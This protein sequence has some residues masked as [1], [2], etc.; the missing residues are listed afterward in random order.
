M[1][2]LFFRSI[3]IAAFLLLYCRLGA[4]V[5]IADGLPGCLPVV[6]KVGVPCGGGT[7]MFDVNG[8]GQFVVNNIDGA[9][10]CSMAGGD[11]E[12]YFEFPSLN[13]AG[14]NNVNI[15]MDYS[16]ANTSYEDNSTG[17]NPIFGCQ[18]MTP[19]DNSHD[20]IIFTYSLDGA[21]FVQGLYLHGTT[22]ADFTGTW[23]EGPLNGNSLV[24]RV[25]AS[26]KAQAEIFYF[27]NLL[28][29]G[30]SS[31]TAGPD[32]EGCAGVP[33][34][35]M[36]EGS[37][38]WTG[39]SGSFANV[40]DP[41]TTYTPAASEQGNDIT[42]TF[43]ATPAYTGCPAT[44]DEMV[45]SVTDGP[46]IVI[47]PDPE[48]C[49]NAVITASGGVSYSWSGGQTPLQAENTFTQSGTYVVTVT[50][51]SGC[52]GTASQQVTVNSS[53][54]VNITGNTTGC[55]SVTLTASGGGP[56]GSYSWSGGS[57]PSSATNT[58]TASGTYVVTVTDGN[59]CTA[60]GSA[61]VTVNQGPVGM[62][63][64]SAVLCPGQCATFS[65]TF[66]SGSGTY[67]VN[68]TANPPG[69]NLPPVPGIT[70][71]ST[72]TVCYQG[73]G[74][75]PT[76]NQ[77]TLTLTIPTTFSGTGGLTLTGIS[78]GSGCPGM[79]SGSFN[80]TL[81]NAPTIQN[82]GPLT[83][84]ANMNGE[85]IFNL[86][87]L[88]GTLTGGNSNLTVNWF[89]DAAGTDPITNPSNYESGTTTVYVSVSNGACSSPIIEVDLIVE[90][91]DVPFISMVCAE[92]GTDICTVCAEN[93]LTDLEFN[94]GDN[95]S[96]SV[97]VREI[98]TGIDYIGTVSN[99]QPLAVLSG[100]SSVF[101]LIN[102]QPLTGCPSFGSYGQ[103][104]TV[105][106]VQKPQ[107]DPVTIP[108]SCDAVVLPPITGN[109]LSGNE[110]YYS[111]PGGTGDVYMPG[112]QI[113]GSITLFLFDTTAPGCEDE[114]QVIITILPVVIFN[115]I[116]DLT[117]CGRVFLPAID[118]VNVSPNA[119]YN[120]APDGSGV[121]YRPNEAIEFNT[122]LY[123]L[124]PEADSECIVNQ[125]DVNITVFPFPSV[126]S[127]EVVCLPGSGT[128]VV[129][130]SSPLDP[131]M[132][133]SLDGIN[134]QNSPVFSNVV[135]G[136]YILRFKDAENECEQIL[137]FSVNCDCAKPAYL[138]I[139]VYDENICAS[140]TFRLSDVQFGGS[141]TNVTLKHNGTG[142]LSPLFSDEWPIEVMYIPGPGDTGNEIT[143]TISTDDPDG[144]APCEP[145]TRAIRVKVRVK[146][147]VSI[148]GPSRICSGDILTLQ[149]SGAVNY[150]WSDN[151][152]TNKDATFP[153]I[154]NART[155][156]VAGTDAFGCRDTAYQTVEVFLVNAGKDTLVSFCKSAALDVNLD[157]YLGSS[158]DKSG[159][160][161]LGA[162]KITTP[163]AYRITDLPVGTN[164]LY[165]ILE[166]AECG[167][168]TAVLAVQIRNFN[169]AGSDYSRNLC[170]DVLTFD[171]TFGLGLFDPGGIWIQGSGTQLSMSNPSAVNI[172]A[173][174]P[175]TYN[176][177]HIIRDNGCLPDSARVI[178]NLKSPPD[179]GPDVSA[180]S[181]IGGIIDLF[182]LI[183][184][185]DK[186]GLIV[187]P[188]GHPGL[189][190]TLLNTAG[191]NPGNYVFGYVI[192]SPE[193]GPDTSQIRLT[194][195]AELSPGADY[196]GSYCPGSTLDLKSYIA[197]DA[198]AGGKFYF[199]NTEILSGVFSTTS[200]Q[201]TLVFIY[202]VGDGTN[203]PEKTAVLTFAEQKA[204]DIT[205]SGLSQICEGR[206][207]DVEIRASGTL[208][209]TL[210]LRVKSQQNGTTFPWTGPINSDKLTFKI[211]AG[212]MG[213]YNFG[214]LPPD[215][216]YTISIDSFTSEG[217][218]FKSN[219]F[220]SF[221][222][223]SSVKKS[224]NPVLCKGESFVLGSD[225][226]SAS[227]PSG[228]TKLFAVPG[229][230]CDTLV[231]VNLTFFPDATG[232]YKADF[233]NEDAV[234]S[235]GN[236]T[237]S[238]TKPSGIAVLQGAAVNGCD[239]TVNVSLTYTN[240][241]AQG[242]FSFTTCDPSYVFTAGN[243]TF[244]KANPEGEV[245]LKGAA[246]MGCDSL[247]KVKLTYTAAPNVGLIQTTDANGVTQI[248][249]DVAPNAIYDLQWTPAEG[250]SCTDCL[251]P[252]ATP[253]M[254][255][256]YVLRY[257]Y[258]NDCVDSTEITITRVS[259]EIVISNIFT[260]DGDGSN[261]YFYVQL[262]NN[263][264]GIVK[265]MR[266][267]DRW[268][269]S[270]FIAENIAPNTPEAG[271]GG[272]FSGK[273][274]QPGVFVYTIEIQLNGEANARI[275]YGNVTLMK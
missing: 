229:T 8:S 54:I 32:R 265:S 84:C 135:N 111:G 94:F 270:I 2:N 74:F 90:E 4:Q 241:I 245:L 36:G 256:T 200:D 205:I 195:D 266:I 117:G 53:P 172:G 127:Y 65:F 103:T 182:S 91:G 37:G 7:T 155:I 73:G 264:D 93:G 137:Q 119:V 21:P 33:I 9:T 220:I 262:P 268:G 154:L 22:Q 255:T 206:C 51:A 175:G 168:D 143:I 227:N 113:S 99:N 62:L 14:F 13:I 124:D 258:G 232:D 6:N 225:T 166:D 147:Q 92:S 140:D 179:A 157:D 29:T 25:Y 164:N 134:F 214:N 222:T 224:L 1:S 152:G 233:C 267:F 17:G 234:V 251:A 80:L 120:T 96:Y 130:F 228:I 149:A 192:G 253:A 58:F 263:F 213:T 48:T 212:S 243:T 180:S 57:N 56:G 145:E 161:Y 61:T 128:A 210:W 217:C 52:T 44:S 77:S 221:S 139:P 3:F 226:Y 66:T 184:A 259:G 209:G 34:S 201:G 87:E 64:G 144:L 46:D 252:L 116:E 75:I 235:I 10:C 38:T 15:S 114:I 170:A 151:G 187:N 238:K 198:D 207:Q 240:F 202:V 158:I 199:G 196:S 185:T 40:N 223:S 183:N 254:T 178:L 138:Y 45:I 89:E 68:L 230:G 28:I 49:G 216:T 231:T 72:F 219:S 153:G 85:A 260:P 101:E 193:C 211:C 203:C 181:C 261:D 271:W 24:I 104:V 71:A 60:T 106:V 272:D 165:Y 59:G 123:I 215:D 31:F 70:A 125:V 190:G 102:I 239:S 274:L 269:N 18:G 41:E 148:S 23:S 50:D 100:A 63:S 275:L 47:T 171:F 186:S 88:N 246:A 189:S 108:P 273:E 67:T 167:K 244:S 118:G 236:Q 98:N 191:L 122:T 208:N 43:T 188:S 169:N 55:N 126:P 11:S 248:L 39:G 69:F 132:L 82:A 176:F 76:W 27:S 16:A 86:T 197:S 19:P 204:P 141:A 133:Y 162:D 42:L 177:L 131:N 163:A 105:N 150:I 81:T 95:D 194:L 30:I 146:P 83:E 97:T 12:S 109:N 78:D 112:D 242:T 247:L 110:A 159:D 174:M 257:A 218:L 115:E 79:A 142:V 129:T 20:Q 237:F 250:L 5:T 156:S 160:W 107:I 121:E 136:T 26:N 35:L 173:L 249:V